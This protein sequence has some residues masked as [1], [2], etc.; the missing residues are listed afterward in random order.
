M[1]QQEGLW[2]PEYARAAVRDA[3]LPH[4]YRYT[5][6]LGVCLFGGLAVLVAL[7]AWGSGGLAL[8]WALLALLGIGV[9]AMALLADP[10]GFLHALGKRLVVTNSFVQEV[11]E[12]DQ[13][14]WFVQPYEVVRVELVRGRPVFPWS[15][16]NGWHVET[17]FLHVRGSRPVQI[18]LW[19]LPERGASFCRRLV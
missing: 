17:L 5:T 4:E 8:C 11:D 16:P 12:K 9:G 7:A 6:W 10:R 3:A 15:G 14:R 18:P 1:N 19:M 2:I 13:V